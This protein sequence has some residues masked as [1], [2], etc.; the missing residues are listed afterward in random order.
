MEANKNKS[1]HW[2]LCGKL[3][4]TRFVIEFNSSTIFCKRPQIK[5]NETLGFQSQQNMLG[6]G[7]LEEK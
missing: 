3:I 2:I 4:L 1:T 7:L 6:T 5:V